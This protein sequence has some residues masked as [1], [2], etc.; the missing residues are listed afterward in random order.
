M[1]VSS[2]SLHVILSTCS[3]LM[4]TSLYIIRMVVLLMVLFAILVQN[5]VMA[6][7]WLNQLAVFNLT[8]IEACIVYVSVCV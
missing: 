3:P 5:M 6:K 4:H 2:M 7:R 8:H 1:L